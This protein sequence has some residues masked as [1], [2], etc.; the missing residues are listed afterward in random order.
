MKRRKKQRFIAFQ[1]H[2][3]WGV[4]D[5][6]SGELVERADMIERYPEAWARNRAE[7]LNKDKAHEQSKQK[8]N[9]DPT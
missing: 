6:E 4:L 9:E 1:L 7:Q 2:D 8:G 3:R 5:R